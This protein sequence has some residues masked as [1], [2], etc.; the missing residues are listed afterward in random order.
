MKWINGRKNDLSKR[1]KI[2]EVCVR[3]CGL[4]VQVFSMADEVE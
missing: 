4:S 3:V 2:D 1:P